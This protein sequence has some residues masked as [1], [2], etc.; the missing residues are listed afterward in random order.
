MGLDEGG[1]TIRLEPKFWRTGA[2]LYIDVCKAVVE[3]GGDMVEL[4]WISE[5]KARLKQQ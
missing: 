4:S 1:T 2:K 5:S 3:S